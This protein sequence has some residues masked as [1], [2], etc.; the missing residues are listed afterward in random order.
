MG[1]ALPG[2]GSSGRVVDPEGRPVAGVTVSAIGRNWADPAVT[3]SAT[4]GPDGRF[5][6]AGAWKLEELDLRYLAL[7]ARAP[8]GRCGWITTV[9]REQ[10]ATQDLILELGEPA[11]IAARLVD[12]EGKPLADI[13]VAPD[14]LD[15]S[16]REEG[17]YDEVVLPRSL[18]GPLATR[19][20]ADGRFAIKGIPRG[21]KVRALIDEPLVGGR[22]SSG[23][24]RRSG[25]W[26][27]IGGSVRSRAGSSRP[28]ARSSGAA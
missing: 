3:A 26:S 11:N 4:T 14:I 18:A 19:T 12:Q 9:W 5:V 23:I 22:G 6:V 21:V 24:R 13:P 20:D 17:M 28:V 27:S 15:R 8:D 16:R 2:R 7:F 25:T 10:P 1:R